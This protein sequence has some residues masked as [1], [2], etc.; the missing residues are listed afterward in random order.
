M[1]GQI[2]LLTCHPACHQTAQISGKYNKYV[3]CAPE[4]T[5]PL[6]I[7]WYK[8]CIQH[9]NKASPPVAKIKD[10]KLKRVLPHDDF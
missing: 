8:A 4:C 7:G 1:V 10:V 5:H 2:G 6:D 9:C 3:S